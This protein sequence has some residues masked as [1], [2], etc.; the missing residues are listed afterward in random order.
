VISVVLCFVLLQV[1]KH[2]VAQTSHV[3]TGSMSPTLEGRD[4]GHGGDYIVVEKIAY[5]FRKPR[6]GDVVLVNTKGVDIPNLQRNAHYVRRIT[7]LPGE[8]VRIKGE[9][10]QLGVDEY[11]VTGDNSEH[12]IDFGPIN[13][14][15]ILG[16]AVW[17]YFPFNRLG[18]IR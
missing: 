9:E 18:R 10:K 5:R 12:S 11:L 15:N 14:D 4:S 7:G 17:I 2:C 8:M 1:M 16:R 13:R 6:K 3:V